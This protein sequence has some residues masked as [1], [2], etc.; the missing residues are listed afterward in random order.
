ML[1][2]PS[3]ITLWIL[4][5]AGVGSFG[6]LEFF[7]NKSNT[8]VRK[9]LFLFFFVSLW[10]LGAACFVILPTY[11]AWIAIALLLIRA[12]YNAFG[13]SESTHDS[14]NESYAVV[15]VGLIGVVALLAG[16][17]A[18]SFLLKQQDNWPY[19]KILARLEEIQRRSY[20]EGFERGGGFIRNKVLL[21]Y[22]LPDPLSGVP[23]L[24]LPPAA[25]IASAC[26]FLPRYRVSGHQE[27]LPDEFRATRAE[28]VG[29]VGL[30]SEVSFSRNYYAEVRPG[31][32]ES[33]PDPNVTGERRLLFVDLIDLASS[34][35]VDARSFDS[36]SAARV[37][38]R[39]GTEAHFSADD[40][41][42]DLP[43]YLSHLPRR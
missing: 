8:H 2:P 5:L 43:S 14:G 1:T 28:E 18:L 16:G 10:V 27:E 4:G 17:H 42:A 25:R 7:A 22:G 19:R 31:Q 12:G 15:T 33:N 38:V 9:V 21:V 11:L 40:P 30:L 3:A 39:A 35:V 37:T 29:T 32:T 23:V 20:R 6:A 41:R 34:R 36:E 24:L 26:T 13:R